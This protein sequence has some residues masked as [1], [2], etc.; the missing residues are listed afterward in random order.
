MRKTKITDPL[1]TFFRE[2]KGGKMEK[3]NHFQN[4]NLSLKI[5][6]IQSRSNKIQERKINMNNQFIM[7]PINFIFVKIQKYNKINIIKLILSLKYIWKV[8]FVWYLFR[9][10][11]TKKIMVQ[12]KGLNDLK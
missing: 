12:S 2:Y 4:D 10:E 7:P 5:F 9:R 11:K 3:M 6:L 1:K 8:L